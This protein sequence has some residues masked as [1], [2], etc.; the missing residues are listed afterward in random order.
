LWRASIPFGHT[1]HLDL[2]QLGIDQKKT[3]LA[4]AGAAK[5]GRGT[6]W[7][8]AVRVPAGFAWAA[9]HPEHFH[10]YHDHSV[11]SF[12]FLIDF[13]V[14]GGTIGPSRPRRGRRLAAI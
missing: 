8:M 6:S 12:E 10:D 1:D 11:V 9:D 14:E 2:T 5:G 7:R 13:G 3:W 4:Y